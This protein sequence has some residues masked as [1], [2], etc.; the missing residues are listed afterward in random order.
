MGKHGVLS[1]RRWSTV[2]KAQVIA[3]LLAGS[4]TVLVNLPMHPAS[5]SSLSN[6]LFFLTLLLYVPTDEIRALIG[7]SQAVWWLPIMEVVVNCVLCA[8]VGTLIGCA[9]AKLKNAR[10]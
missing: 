7:L 4:V 8:V 3:V 5:G 1:W 6:N 2:G 10:K 9:I